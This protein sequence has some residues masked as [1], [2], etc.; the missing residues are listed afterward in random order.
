MSKKCKACG[1]HFTPDPR[2]P[3][4]QFCSKPECQLQRRKAWQ[5]DKRRHDP[6]YRDNDSR[7]IREWITSH[8]D[9]WKLYR[10]K[11]PDYAK[12]NRDLQQ[13][14]N[15]KQKNADLASHEV[16]LPDFHL[17]SGRY[18]LR[19]VGPDGVA[20]EDAWIVEITLISVCCDNAAT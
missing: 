13:A 20:N 11:N 15:K 16:V 9:Y 7:Q 8:P 6:H 1:C 12:R 19:L 14:R 18:V 3:K 5:Q 17:V 10:Q 4:Q 2:V